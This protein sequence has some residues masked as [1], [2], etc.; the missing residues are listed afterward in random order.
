MECGAVEH[1]MGDGSS[2]MAGRG[3]EGLIVALIS[4]LAAAL[5][6]APEGVDGEET[7]IASSNTRRCRVKYLIH[8]FQAQPSTR[9][10]FIAE[11]GANSGQTGGIRGDDEKETGTGSP[12]AILAFPR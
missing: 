11:Y 4:R 9:G 8:L 12:A 2:I 10:I 7:P 5:C 6:F 3:P 1:R